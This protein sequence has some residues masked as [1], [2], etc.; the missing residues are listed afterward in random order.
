[1]RTRAWALARRLIDEW[2]RRGWGEMRTHIGLHDQVAA[3][4]DFNDCALLRLNE[5]VKE[6]FDPKG[7]IAPGK[8]GIWPRGY[9][10]AKWLMGREYIGRFPGVE[11]GDLVGHVGNGANGTNGMNGKNGHV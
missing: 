2:A 10:R 5:R 8:S 1:M 7:I 3:S 9:D 6:A 11:E 4:Y